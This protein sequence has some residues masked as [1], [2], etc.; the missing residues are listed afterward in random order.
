MPGH[1][2]AGNEYTS[3]DDALNSTRFAKSSGL[4]GKFSL[5]CDHASDQITNMSTWMLIGMMTWDI[6]RDCDQRKGYPQGDDNLFQTG[7]PPATFLNAISAELNKG[8]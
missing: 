1:H 3:L 7:L 8:N 5:E 4:A 6:N 2:D